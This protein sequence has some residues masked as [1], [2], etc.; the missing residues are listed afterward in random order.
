MNK[1]QQGF[2]LIELIIVIVILGILAVTASPKFLDIQGDAQ[3]SALQ[4]VKGALDGSINI[5]YGKAV[6]AGKHK[7]ASQT[8]ETIPTDFGYPQATEAALEAAMEINLN[9]DGSSGD[10][11][12]KATA[13]AGGAAAKIEIFP[14][15]STASDDTPAGSCYITYT[16]ALNATTKA[17]VTGTYTGC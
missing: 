16:A 12:F 15:G 1:K 5:V 9:A 3:E 2:T 4:G 7:L 17:T 10:F 13:A 6:I 14:N 11:D 8:V